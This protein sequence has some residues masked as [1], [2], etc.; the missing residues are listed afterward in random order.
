MEKRVF[1]FI[2]CLMVISCLTVHGAGIPQLINYQG[3]LLDSEGDPITDDQSIEFLM[4]NVETEG[5]ALWSETQEVTVT[6]GL[7]NVLLGS[8]TPIPH[9][10]FDSTDVYLALK[11]ESDEEMEPRKRLVSVGY[12]F[13]AYNSDNL[14]GKDNSAFVQSLNNVLPNKGKIDLVAGSNVTITPD[15]SENEITISATPGSGGDNLG[16][17]TATQNI[18]LNRNWLSGDGDSEG[19]FITNDGN[20]GIGIMNPV[21]KLDVP[22]IIRVGGFTWPDSGVGLELAYNAT[23]NQGYI[24]VYDRSHQTWGNLYL[25]NGNVGIGTENPSSKLQ[26]NGIIYS[27]SGGIKFPDN[28]TQT[29]AAGSSFWTSVGDDICSNN[30]GDIGIGDTSPTFKLDIAGKIGINDIQVLFLPDQ[31]DFTGTLIIGN[32]GGS[33]SHSASDQGRYNTAV[34]IE[35]LQTNTT[36]SENTATGSGALYSNTAGQHNTAHGA[37]ALYNNTTG[38]F[39]VAIGSNALNSNTAGSQNIAIGNALA[40]NTTGNQNTAVGDQALYN[41][42]IGIYNTAVGWRALCKNTTGEVN[43]AIGR[44]ALAYNTTG[45]WNT[46]VGFGG[47]E[48]NTTGVRNTATG[49][50][51]LYSNTTANDNTATGYAALYYNTIGENN[52]AVGTQALYVN[53][54][55]GFNTALGQTALRSNTTGNNNTAMGTSALSSNITGYSNTA[56][57]VQTLQNNTIGHENTAIGYKALLS[58]IEGERNTATGMF[59][60]YYNTTGSFNTATGL[61]ALYNNTAGQHNT[62]YG[63]SALVDNTSGHENTACG[64]G[65]LS[66]NNTG[67]RNTA[68]G[69]YA[70]V[71]SNNLYNTTAIG[72]MALVNANNKVV[73]GNSSVASIG[74]YANWTNYSDRRYK[75]NIVEKDDLGLNFIMKLKTVSYNYMND[76]YKRRRDGLIAQDVEEALSELGAEFSGLVV[77]DDDQKTMNLSYG[78]FVIPLINAVKEQQAQIEMLKAEIEALKQ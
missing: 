71:S 70:D 34:G 19:I 52:T 25:G 66:T 49:Y 3:V 51:A 41:N 26:V 2:V 35:A 18:G 62:S 63:M 69:Y 56:T 75:E 46:A 10:V 60:L 50:L 12:A 44:N 76:E 31:T 23:V 22:D 17:H 37:N 48:A 43:T 28:T 55:G 11:V 39:N 61:G 67:Y 6:D 8:V 57:G 45:S 16:N 54:E 59:A 1:L 65:A 4:Y 53:T 58:N 42:T 78:D 24:Q 36:G 74:G 14:N 73:I 9:E 32:G 64:T 13:R 40:L 68:I 38:V 20:V 29:T 30:S 77:D 27:T 5:T 47:L 33:L 7:F 72:Y 21:V 15:T